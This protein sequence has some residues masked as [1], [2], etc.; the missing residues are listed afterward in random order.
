MRSPLELQLSPVLL[1][2]GAR[3]FDGLEGVDLRFTLRSRCGDE[4][5]APGL[6]RQTRLTPRG[7]FVCPLGGPFG[8]V[9]G[10]HRP[11]SA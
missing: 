9:A 10:G 2:G 8:R 3:L 5:R 6:R 7:W 1:H 4:R 11:V